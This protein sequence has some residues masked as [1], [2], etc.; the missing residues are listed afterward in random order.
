MKYGRSELQ[1]RLAFLFTL[2]Y[3]SSHSSHRET[4]QN[5]TTK[6][7]K[8]SKIKLSAERWSGRPWRGK[9]NYSL[10]PWLAP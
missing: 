6:S 4:K 2:L 9:A 3:T 10:N 1:G 5:K 8:K 7:N